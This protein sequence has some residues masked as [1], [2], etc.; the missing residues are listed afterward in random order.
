MKL[1]PSQANS[2]YYNLP[3]AELVERAIAN[4][5]ASLSN[6]GALV[7]RTGK[8]TGRT[9]KDKCTVRDTNTENVV[10]WGSNNG[11]DPQKFQELWDKAKASLSDQDVY[12]VDTYG[13]A[14]PAYRIK[15]RF[16]T[17]KAWHALF[18]KTLLIRPDAAGLAA[19]EPEWEIL[20]ASHISFDPAVDGTT[21]D[22]VIALDMTNKKVLIVG[23]QY[24]GEMKK[25]VFTILNYLLPLQGVM[26]MHCSSNIGVGGDTA[27]FFGLSGT[28][29]TTLSADPNRRLIGDDEHGWSDNGV[30]NIEGGCYAKCVNLS[31]EKEPQIFHAVKFGSVLENV[32]LDENHVPDY[33][34][35]SLTENTRCAYPLEFIDNAVHPSVGGHPQNIVFLTADAFGV[36]PP[37]SKLTPE[38]AMEHF[39]NGYTAKVA[40]TEAGVTE[41]Q[42][43]FSA[44]FG[45]PF[46][47]LPPKVY[48]ELLK[49]KIHRHGAHVW[50]VNTGWSGGPYGVGKR[51]H[52]PYTRAMLNAALAGQ[53]HDVEYVTDPVFGLSV[54]QSCPEVPSEILNPRNTWADKDAYDAHAQ[55]LKAMFAENYR[56]MVAGEATPGTAG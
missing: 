25:S 10:W 27:L 9:P 42:A 3:T 52:L 35:I 39:L 8:Y 15:A 55:K 44:C 7:A 36:L 1:D 12:V 49:E 19:F 17:V 40:G 26:S 4:G 33:A 11:L 41:P 5:E 43:T 46:L 2:V 51:M 38:Q 22:A 47:P 28:G 50:L 54:P 31:E 14:D 21:G 48:A 13:G 24:A 53:L 23:T 20:N 37:I 18:I 34:D 30:F 16:Y 45:Q 29:K 32:I 6:L 56:K